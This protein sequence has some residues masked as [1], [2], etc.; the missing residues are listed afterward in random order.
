MSERLKGFCPGSG[1]RA[2]DEIASLA[3]ATLAADRRFG[4]VFPGCVELHM[5]TRRLAL[6]VIGLLTATLKLVNVRGALPA[7]LCILVAGAGCAHDRP[8]HPQLAVS[9]VFR[10]YTDGG[11]A[12]RF[13][14][15]DYSECIQQYEGPY[16]E[17]WDGA[18]WKNYRANPSEAAVREASKHLTSR[19]QTMTVPLPP[20]PVRWRASVDCVFYGE[21]RGRFVVWSREFQR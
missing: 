15:I 2:P 4:E 19:R 17:C 5:K 18:A 11:H 9:F 10:G 1:N 12:A 6:T 14:L 8:A 7:L 3:A 20:G 13:Q 21:L 16:V